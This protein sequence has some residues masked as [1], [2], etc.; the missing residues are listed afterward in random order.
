MILKKSGL[1][2]FLFFV[3]LGLGLF[4]WFNLYRF[5]WPN[6]KIKD[7]DSYF[8]RQH[9]YDLV[10]WQPFNSATF[11]HARSVDKPLL[12]IFGQSISESH[13]KIQ[14]DSFRHPLIAKMINRYFVPILVD[15]HQQPDIA[16]LYSNVKLRVG[17]SGWPL[18]VMATSDGTPLFLNR[19][20]SSEL[21]ESN[22][23][24]FIK[25][26]RRN[27]VMFIDGSK[28]WGLYYESLFAPSNYSIGKELLYGMDQFIQQFFDPT[29]YSMPLGWN[30]MTPFSLF[31]L[32]LIQ[33]SSKF[34]P[35]VKQLVDRILISPFFDM[36][37]GGVHSYSISPSW[38]RPL[39]GKTLIDQ[40]RFIQ[41]LIELHDQTQE[42]IY[43]DMT[44]FNLSFVISSFKNPSG[45]FMNAL[46]SYYKDTPGRYYMIQ[47][48]VLDSFSP[49]NY[50]R[51]P[52]IDNHS[53]V[54]LIKRDDFYGV[55]RDD[56]IKRRKQLRPYLMADSSVFLR[57]NA[58]L[59][60]VLIQLNERRAQ[61]EYQK[62]IDQL[63]ESLIQSYDPK[64]PI[65]DR[66]IIYDALSKQYSLDRLTKIQLNIQQ[67]LAQEFPFIKK[68]NYFSS[69]I[70]VSLSDLIHYKHPLFYLLWHRKI[71][72]PS[73]SKS[74][75]CMDIRSIIVN[76]WDQ[77]SLVKLYNKSCL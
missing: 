20:H 76:P 16:G 75:M 23:N 21:L 74:Q 45:Q 26:W 30:V 24:D 14:K 13:F 40:I 1:F 60:D 42:T 57:D 64:L 5:V 7:S 72:L 12:I 35:Q 19:V 44:R 29:N 34:T 3:T 22:L 62:L 67:D 32:H 53:L 50:Q 41:L 66:L 17:H 6:F 56:L 69:S 8:I 61:S 65:L 18:I 58:I 71:F 46:H 39:L 36:V 25:E 9:R 63:S 52:Y 4:L 37:D 31:W 68:H 33:D 48:D 10:R 59:L 77:I 55:D 38:D 73:Y 15:I 47:D 54:A 51:I 49:L 70:Q 43:L 28:D 11:E 2:R 27:S